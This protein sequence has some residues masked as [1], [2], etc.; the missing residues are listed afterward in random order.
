MAQPLNVAVLG[1]GTA[2][3]VLLAPALGNVEELRL[4]G[5]VSRSMDRALGFAEKHGTRGRALRVFDD[6]A[7]CLAEPDLHAIIVATP[8]ALHAKQIIMAAQA[9]KHV[10]CEKPLATS[11]D[12]AQAIVG[13]CNLHGVRLGVGYHHRWHAG[14]RMVQNQLRDGVIG[15][16]RHMRV[17]WTFKARNN[18]NWRAK[19]EMSRWWSLAGVGT[20]ALDM[21]RWWMMPSC[22]EVVQARAMISRSTYGGPNDETACILLRFESGATAELLSSV[23]FESPRRIDLF[24]TSGAVHCEGTL[25]PYGEG[26]ISVLGA[27]MHWEVVNPYEGELR[28]FALAILEG[29]DP[30]VSGEEALRNVEILEHASEFDLKRPATP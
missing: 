27:D 5:V 25:G 10:F 24:G 11:S 9:G 21:I 2:A 8:D 16:L 13:A 30:E 1:T 3:D 7:Q 19:R 22:G 4:W 14:H 18:E 20:H 15:D 23:L 26:F 6:F 28:D 29:R 17:Q 12:D